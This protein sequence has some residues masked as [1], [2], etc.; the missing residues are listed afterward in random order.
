[1]IE[2]ALKIIGNASNVIENALKSSE[3]VE[4]DRK[5]FEIIGNALKSSEM[6]RK[7]LEML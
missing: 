2:N 1:M 4:N 6:H 5:C 7:S 3:F